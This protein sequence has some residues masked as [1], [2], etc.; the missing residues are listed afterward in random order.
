MFI[1]A[2]VAV[3]I[4]DIIFACYYYY[5]CLRSRCFTPPTQTPR[6]ADSKV[7][8]WRMHFERNIMRFG[9]QA[10]KKTSKDKQLPFVVITY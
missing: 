4:N 6:L 7:K 1:I 2:S 3:S 10:K 5:C 8:I 9:Y